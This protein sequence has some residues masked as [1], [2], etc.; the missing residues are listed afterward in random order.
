MRGYLFIVILLALFIA[1]AWVTV[2][3]TLRARRATSGSWQELLDRLAKVSHENVALVALDL[4]DE[5]GR[6]R[7]QEWPELSAEQ[8]WNLVGGMEGLE[9]IEANCKV[10]IDIAVYVQVTYP[11]AILVAE[12]LRRNTR[13]IQ[14]HVDRLRASAETGNVRS[15]FTTYAQRAVASYYLM[16]KQLIALCEKCHFAGTEQLRAAV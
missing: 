16:T 15:S 6:V 3:Y 12:E 14:W 9:E 8:I 4:I 7:G 1:I 5:D 2:H 11:E 13:H 10:L